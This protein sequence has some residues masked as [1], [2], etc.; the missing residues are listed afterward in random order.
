[1]VKAKLAARNGVGAPGAGA[2]DDAFRRWWN[3]WWRDNMSS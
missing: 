1:M 3:T 2:S